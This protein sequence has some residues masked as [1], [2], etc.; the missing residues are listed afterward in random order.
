[1]TS[2]TKKVRVRFAPSPT[3]AL[4]IGG[5]RTALYNFLFARQHEGVFI[6]RIEDTDQ[7][8]YVEGAENYIADALEWVGLIPDESPRKGGKYGPYRQ[9]ERMDIYKKYALQLVEKGHAY[10]A[11]DTPEQ[12]EACREKDP[13][14]KYDAKTRM[15]LSNSLSI[16]QSEAEVLLNSGQNIVIRMKVEPGQ[17]VQIID[18]IRGE[19]TFQSDELDD[20]VILKGDGMPT[21]HLANIV[22]DHL[23]E[24]SHVIRGEEWLPS[25]AHHKLLYQFFDWEAPVFAHLPL[26]LK[27]TGQGKLSKR[28]GATFGFPVFPLEWNS[29]DGYF[30]GFREEGF[31][32]EA[33]INFLGLIGWSPG[34]EQEIFSIEQLTKQ[35]SL[36]KI[37]KAGS[38]FDYNKAKWFNQH[39]II[40]SDNHDLARLIQQSIEQKFNQT[41]STE[42]IASVCGLMKERVHLLDEIMENALFFFTEDFP[43][44]ADTFQKKWKPENKIHFE[45]LAAMIQHSPVNAESAVKQY[46]Q[47]HSLKMGDILPVLRIAVSGTMQ[48]PDLFATMHLIGH[49]VSAARILKSLPA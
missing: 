40:H 42:Y 34:N 16:S 13:T 10:Y 12:L 26:I 38:R 6:L 37:H 7:N 14:F 30:Q 49:E 35:F 24:I 22:D 32:P 15:T 43:Y 11:F 33:V 41:F 2:N 23:M 20:K 44:D 9:S 46:I 36:E 27:P 48:G 21:Y 1:M 39:Y 18:Q 19:V 28:D 4:H 45:A 3:G 31:L 29:S 25:T 17:S 8:R 5:V 47:D